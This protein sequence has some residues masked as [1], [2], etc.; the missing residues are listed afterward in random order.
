[1]G[2]CTV[3]FAE[4]PLRVSPSSAPLAPAPCRTADGWK[5]YDLSSYEIKFFHYVYLCSRRIQK[6]IIH[7]K[8]T[9][10][11]WYIPL[12]CFDWKPSS[13]MSMAI[14]IE[15]HF[16]Q[17]RGHFASECALLLLNARRRWIGNN[18]GDEYKEALFGCSATLVT[19]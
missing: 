5:R 4:C 8:V 18:N 9:T 12:F 17:N 7:E 11:F 10:Q 3:H 2:P 16:N 1:M 14:G 6:N 15:C 13:G 19:R